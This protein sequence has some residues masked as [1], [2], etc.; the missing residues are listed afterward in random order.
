MLPGLA[1]VFPETA[2]FD[3]LRPLGQGG[4]G[5][6]FAA[7]DRERGVQVAIKTISERNHDRLR[8]FKKEFRALQDLAHPNLVRLGELLEAD[9]RWFFTMELVEGV[10]LL[11]YVTHGLPAQDGIEEEPE[12]VDVTQDIDVLSSAFAWPRGP[13]PQVWFSRVDIPRLRSVLH[14]LASAL[15]ALHSVRKVH[16][17]IKPANLLVT[18]AGRLVLLDFGIVS[19]QEQEAGGFRPAT[20]GTVAYMAPEQADGVAVTPA[21]DCFSLGVLLYES[22]S[23]RLPFEGTGEQIMDRKRRGLWDA[24]SDRIADA[25]TDLV[26]LCH[27]L[28]HPDP[29]ARPGAAAVLH[30][31]APQASL[32]GVGAQAPVPP[33]AEAFVGRQDELS[34]LSAAFR[35]ARAGHGQTLLVDGESGIGKSTLVRHFLASLPREDPRTVVLCGRCY[36]RESVPFKGVDAIVDQ[37][38]T[39]L[40]TRSADELSALLPAAESMARLER[41][42]PVLQGL[43][44]RS[45]PPASLPDADP[46]EMRWS[47][48]R[49]LREMWTRIAQSVPLVLSIDDLQW[50]DE[51]SLAL[52]SDVLRQPEA[53]P[54]LLLATVR[55][56]PT[57]GA[58]GTEPSVLFRLGATVRRLHVGP[59]PQADAQA[60]VAQLLGQSAAQDPASGPPLASEPDVDTRVLSQRL[61]HEAS[62][63]PLFIDHLVR[64]RRNGGGTE[65]P[66][67]LEDALWQRVQGLAPEAHQLLS[68][69]AVAGVPIVQR[70]AARAAALSADRFDDLSAQ[71]RVARLVQS[72]G[73][74]ASDFIEPYH[75]RVRVA[76]LG[77][78]SPEA[79]RSVHARLA[80]ALTLEDRPDP[81]A[82]LNHFHAAGLL[83]QAAAYAI[84]AAEQAAS[85][86][87]F[88]RAA[89]LYKR[90]LDLLQP[91]GAAHRD[92]LIRLG[93]AQANAGRGQLAG[94]TLLAAAA[95]AVPAQARTLRL[96]AA[97]Q[98][99]RS[100]RSARGIELLRDVLTELGIAHK[101]SQ[102]GVLADLLL[103]RARLAYRPPARVRSTE[104][105]SS[106]ALERMD[107]CMAAANGYLFI[108]RMRAM[109]FY[110]LHLEQALQVGEPERLAISLSYAALAYAWSA[111]PADHI[112]CQQLLD[113]ARSVARHAQAPYPQGVI[114]LLSGILE[115][116]SCRRARARELFTQA[117]SLLQERCQGVYWDLCIV[118]LQRLINDQALGDLSGYLTQ[119]PRYLEDAQARND[120]N[121]LSQ[122][123]WE[124]WPRA[125]LIQDQPQE[126]LRVLADEQAR[127]VAL[128]SGG[129]NGLI[130][131]FRTRAT[132]YLYMGDGAAAYREMAHKLSLSS[133]LFLRRSILHRVMHNEHKGRCAVA[134]AL[135]QTGYA[136]RRLLQE[137]SHH[138][139]ELEKESASWVQSTALLLRAGITRAQGRRAEARAAYRLA[140]LALETDELPLLACVARYR[141]AQLLPASES[142]HEKAAAEAVLLA[143][144]IQNP[145]R[146]IRMISPAVD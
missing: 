42:F 54:L 86:L 23:G 9:G 77:H 62:G 80:Q 119:V 66:L 38:C 64:V 78:L 91:T 141:Y 145:Q 85:A 103:S 138:A 16:C 136:R 3:V 137:A 144:K 52:L 33:S 92:L 2:R 59:L 101:E 70:C 8:L 89:A 11:S 111:R 40:R 117:E 53:P 41:V 127:Y 55:T 49:A 93:Q 82:L 29:A 109:Y 35:Q 87:A 20:M 98:F 4:M 12:R 139:S 129:D 112:R 24:L 73:G 31:L 94:E 76:V 13:S 48:F 67:R 69:L 96:D 50:A 26:E 5:T 32:L 45:E 51:D 7:W 17:D 122:L 19:D 107:A 72:T 121:L 47:A 30:A 128:S 63:H 84:P 146:W 124:V 25:P 14:Q 65:Q 118:R 115:M 108:N 105:V 56:A 95:D 58:R 83:E 88:D 75:D 74:R 71:L 21:A 18:A 126:A 36:E 99:L 28:L 43:G 140:Q 123:S 104:N 131:L 132:V 61:A 22:L 113:E 125:L 120:T 110:N 39:Y 130:Q 68:T 46:V 79:Q 6:V 116:I 1:G 34:V 134:G 81:E 100:G 102:A 60:L 44:G 142:S 90:A 15:A 106:E 57:E 97:S 143:Q 114:L 37:V 135:A 133:Q 27:A 10:D